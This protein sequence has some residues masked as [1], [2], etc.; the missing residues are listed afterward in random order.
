MTE[1]SEA[2]EVQKSA[3]VT[4]S[5]RGIG[6]AAA[7]ALAAEG[8]AVGLN[9]SSENSRARTQ[10]AA[11]E[12]AAQF[13]VPTFVVVANVADAA[14]AK[15]LVDAAVAQFGRLDVLVNN[16]G[17]TRDGLVAR[18]SEQDFDDVIAVN[19]KGTFNCSKA[20]AKVMMKQ[21]SGAIINMSSVVGLS[22]NAGQ[23][24]YAASKAGV[25][26][27]TKSLAKEL[28]RRSITVNAIAPGYISTDMTGAL[29]DEQ[30]EAISSHIGLGRLGQPEDV[31]A[32][33]AFLASPAASYI[34]GQVISV[35]GGLA[36]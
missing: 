31:A 35:D 1:K 30:R 9:C 20:A 13:G 36:L 18:M 5:G 6:L 26:G 29:T 25:V 24:N 4:G 7:K 19:L 11:D 15:A 32:V 23:V 33:V 8:F 3:L 10:Q 22:G 16:A 14:E 21:R 2:A 12:I 28:A 17:I 27:M 34:T